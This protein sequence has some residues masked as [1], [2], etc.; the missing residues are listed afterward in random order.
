[1]PLKGYISSP[2]VYIT[3][4]QQRHLSSVGEEE[5]PYLLLVVAH[6]SWSQLL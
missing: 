2:P 3:I 4:A 6:E 5:E 1:M